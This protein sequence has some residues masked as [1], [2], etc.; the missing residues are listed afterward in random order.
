M[1]LARTK[2]VE[3]LLLLLLRGAVVATGSTCVEVELGS[4][5]TR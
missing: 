3:V 1:A 2:R 4:G 5:P